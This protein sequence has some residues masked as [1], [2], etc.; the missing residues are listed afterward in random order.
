[1]REDYERLSALGLPVFVTN[2]RSL[3]GIHH[4]ILQLG[5][6]TG[7]RDSASAV[8]AGMRRL[9]ESVKDKATGREPV[10][11][12]LIVSVHPLMCAGKNTF[13]NQLIQ[14]AGGE[15]LA[16]RASG[17]Y[18]TYSREAVVQDN[19]QVL[20]AM[21]DAGAPT[22]DL[23]RLFPEWSSISAVRGHCVFRI[24]SDL[25]SRPGPRAA[26]AL[27]SLFSLLHTPCR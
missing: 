18:P 11:A 22:E 7:N 10:R 9:E 5:E 8:V 4:S 3:E 14:L 13:I 25:V 12:L 26:A 15:N 2:P 6:L 19:P 21:S 23:P 1:M 16:Q 17:S 27:A 20:I 24:D